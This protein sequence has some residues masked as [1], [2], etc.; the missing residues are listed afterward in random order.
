[1]QS[2]SDQY[3]LFNYFA[4]MVNLGNTNLNQSQSLTQSLYQ[5]ANKYVVSMSAN[6]F[7]YNISGHMGAYPTLSMVS[8]LSYAFEIIS[9]GNPFAICD[10]ATAEPLRED[11]QHIF[12]HVA[13]NGVVTTGNEANAGQESGTLIWT[14]PANFDHAS[15]R[16]L[17]LGSNGKISFVNIANLTK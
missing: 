16:S 10:F 13:V 4:S 17:S 12:V 14:V 7:D 9:N 2:I 3:R 8:G 1:M 6:G 15:Y 11:G 5:A